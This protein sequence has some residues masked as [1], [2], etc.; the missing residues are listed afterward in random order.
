MRIAGNRIRTIESYDYIFNRFVQFSKLEYVALVMTE[1]SR[2][3]REARGNSTLVIIK[4]PNG[5][6]SFETIYN[7]IESLIA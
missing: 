7:I 1:D 3:I 6:K 4:M 2:A 5:H